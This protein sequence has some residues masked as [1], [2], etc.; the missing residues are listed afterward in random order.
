MKLPVAFVW[1]SVVEMCPSEKH[2]LVVVVVAVDV[3]AV[4]GLAFCFG[5]VGDGT[6]MTA[7]FGFPS[8]SSEAGLTKPTFLFGGDW[9][10]DGGVELCPPSCTFIACF[11]SGLCSPLLSEV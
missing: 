3:P 1:N 8:G 9:E 11:D 6:E 4:E 7:W 10:Q 5:L 2:L